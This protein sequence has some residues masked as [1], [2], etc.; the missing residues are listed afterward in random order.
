MAAA[1]T[2]DF[3]LVVLRV[4]SDRLSDAAS[5][6][7]S[8]FSIDETLAEQVCRSAPVVLAE[9]L[10]KAELKE[11]SPVLADVSKSGV[12]F[13]VTCRPVSRLPK[14][15]LPPGAKYSRAAEAKEAGFAWNHSAF[16]CP[17]CGET[18]LFQRP[19]KLTIG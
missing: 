6:L 16:V 10:S 9:A 17:C 1:E 5:S 19:P 12:E 18:F 7:A 15:T 13:R 4:E 8:A 3:N 11:I 14:C 2:G